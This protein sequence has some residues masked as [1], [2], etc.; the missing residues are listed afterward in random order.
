MSE[1]LAFRGLLGEVASHGALLIATGP[2][3]VDPETYPS[4]DNATVETSQNPAALTE[5]I[6]WVV[7]NAGQGK[8]AHVDASRIAVWGQSCGGLEAYSAGAQ[9][10]RVGHLGIFNSGQLTEEESLAVASNI[11]KP[12]FYFLGGPTDVAYEN[13][14]KRAAS[15]HFFFLDTYICFT[16]KLTGIKGERDY[17]DLPATTPAFL[18]NHDKGHSAAFDELNAGVAGIA[19]THLMQWLLRGNVTAKAWF[20]EDGWNSTGFVDAVYQN[21]DSITVTPI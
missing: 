6:D 19:G 11:T 14:S 8:Y 1:G 7:A 16:Q 3:F 12:I 4:N 18:G 10:G 17:S 21:L 15:G 20:T 2:A 13:V 5:A 9:D